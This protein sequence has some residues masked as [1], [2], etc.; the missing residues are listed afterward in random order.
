MNKQSFLNR[1][2]Y[3]FG[4]PPPKS[5]E[6]PWEK[7]YRFFFGDDIFISYSRADAIRYVPSLAARLTALRHICFFDQL[8]ADPSNELPKRLKKKILRSSVFVLIGTRGAVASSFV[9]KEVELFRRTRRPFI[10]VDVDGALMEQQ[11]W[12]SVIGMAKI[13]EEGARVRDG[14]PSPEVVNLIKDSFRYTRRNQWLRASLLAGVSVIFVTAVTSLLVI[15]VART[16]AAAIQGQAAA[17]MAA[18]NKKV[19]EAQTNLDRITAEADQAKADTNVARNQAASAVAAVKVASAQREVAE[20]G[21]RQAQELERDSTARA[22]DTSRREA[23]SRAALLSRKPGME[24]D[25]LSLAVEAAEQSIAHGGVLR[26]E[27]LNGITASA[28]ASD[29]SLPLEDVGVTGSLISPNGQKILGGV[30][31]TLTNATRLILWDAR[32]G[33]KTADF[34]T[35]GLV[36][37]WAFSRDGR[38]LATIAEVG[39][40]SELSFWDLDGSEPRRLQS[41]CG[42]EYV[43]PNL[44]LDS[45]GS[46]AIFDEWLPDPSA[47]LTVCEVAT[48]RKERL[49]GMQSVL[50][51]AFTPDDEP[52][53]YGYFGPVSLPLPPRVLYFP[54][55]GRQVTPKF[56]ADPDGARLAGFGDDG[57]LII[58]VRNT[59]VPLGQGRIYVQS[60][61]GDVHRFGGY[62]GAI[63]SAAFVSGQAHVVTLS[64]RGTR[65]ADAL[66]STNFAALRAHMR[67]VDMVAVSPDARTAITVSDDGKGR[68]WDTQTWGLRHTLAISEEYLYDGG[69]SLQRSKAV[70]FRADSK[71]LVTG[72][73]KGEIQTWDVDTGRPVCAVPGRRTGPN[74]Y[75]NGLSFL[76][77]CDYLLAVYSGGPTNSFMNLLDARTC[78]TVGTL[79]LAE[80][81]MSVWFSRDGTSMLTRAYS[82]SELATLGTLG[83]L[84]SAWES[85]ELELWSLRG[86]NP[87]SAIPTSLPDPVKVKVPGFM[88]GLSFDAGRVLF[89][90]MDTTGQTWVSDGGSPVRLEKRPDDMTPIFRFVF[91]ADGTR[92]AGVSWKGASVWD[93][94][95]GK[96]LLT[97]EC[98]ADEGPMVGPTNPITFSPDASKLLIASRDNT[99]RVYPTSREAFM[100]AAKRLLGR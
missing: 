11:D 36:R 62:R 4:P 75:L 86:I 34:S 63:A 29:Y 9:R 66:R 93:T 10:P 73:D 83:A 21:M 5:I 48:G 24:A 95:S 79:S 71:R 26:D 41:P 96:L 56:F 69:Q 67:P 60:P 88:Y 2:A 18:A 89:A 78:E 3:D 6:T 70:A 16:E 81:V 37:T 46:H 97:F 25:A 15:R 39:K 28:D 23:G 80:R 12:A 82:P 90:S 57:S 72:N 76:A 74:D 33:R 87:A 92:A 7:V 64:G 53:I 13:R 22:A 94:R 49:P 19:G 40:R 38:R 35:A 31:L 27:V 50:G 43:A 98:D 65:V 42:L 99:V 68:L 84:A 52:A 32:T 59:T 17:E 51:A 1:D 47:K 61:G 85:H 14:D 100:G 8:A 44:A 20:Y 30:I 58:I 54:R 45:D 77:G 55:S 91:S